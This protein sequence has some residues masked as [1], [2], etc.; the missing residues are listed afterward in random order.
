ML[1][2]RRDKGMNMIYVEEL[3][4][5]MEECWAA[6]SGSIGVGIRFSEDGGPSKWLSTVDG[7]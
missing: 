3:I 7:E 1:F 5:R 6:C 4:C 2:I